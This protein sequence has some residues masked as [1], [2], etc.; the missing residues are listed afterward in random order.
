M[1]KDVH[2]ISH[3]GETLVSA[4][5]WLRVPTWATGLSSGPTTATD[6]RPELHALVSQRWALAEE[7]FPALPWSC[8]AKVFLP[9][10]SHSSVCWYHSSQFW[11]LQYDPPHGWRWQGWTW[12][13]VLGALEGKCMHVAFRESMAP[14]LRGATR[15]TCFWDPLLFPAWM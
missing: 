8:H 9:V 1:D 13:N 6:N 2:V 7:P 10:S 3:E 15:A 11:W 5:E 12:R 4:C 14:A